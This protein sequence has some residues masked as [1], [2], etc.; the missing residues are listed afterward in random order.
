MAGSRQPRL[1]TP[2]AARVLDLVARPA[3]LR[4]LRLLAAR[5][6]ASA[7]DVAAAAGRSLNSAQ[8]HLRLLCRHG[9]LASRKVGRRTLYRICGPLVGKVLR[10]LGKG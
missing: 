3:R 1:T 2:E 7:Q 4:L 10:L 9:L 5:G 6:E 8:N